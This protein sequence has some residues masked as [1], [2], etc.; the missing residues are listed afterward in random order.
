MSAAK[1]AIIVARILNQIYKFMPNVNPNQM[2]R[3]QGKMTE[4]ML[5]KLLKTDE[6]NKRAVS[7]SQSDASLDRV[8]GDH[9]IRGHGGFC[10]S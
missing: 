3:A 1:T 2:N 5:G 4:K 7:I 10:K 8:D 6:D 9:L